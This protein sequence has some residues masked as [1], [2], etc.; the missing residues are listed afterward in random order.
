ME[1]KDIHNAAT[2]FRRGRKDLD[3]QKVIEAHLQRG[4]ILIARRHL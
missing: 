4:V 3:F 1:K 2:V